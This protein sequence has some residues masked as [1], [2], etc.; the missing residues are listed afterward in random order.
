MYIYSSIDYLFVKSMRL[1]IRSN[2]GSYNPVWIT[3]R[4]TIIIN[5]MNKVMIWTNS[6]FLYYFSTHQM[7]GTII[8]NLMCWYYLCRSFFVVCCNAVHSNQMS[9][10]LRKAWYKLCVG[11]KA[12]FPLQKFLQLLFSISD[13]CGKWI[14]ILS[15]KN[16]NERFAIIQHYGLV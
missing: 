6:F 16:M 3:R 2:F 7:H 14:A 13:E 9:P 11:L 1:L 12:F 15:K 10:K 4:Y 5:S 8:V